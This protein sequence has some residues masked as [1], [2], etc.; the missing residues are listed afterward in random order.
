MTTEYLL[1]I[2]FNLIFKHIIEL[3]NPSADRSF[4]TNPVQYVLRKSRKKVTFPNTARPG[5]S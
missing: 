3:L 4:Y 2:T 5:T 1:M